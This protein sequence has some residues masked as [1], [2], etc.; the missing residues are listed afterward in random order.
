MLDHHKALGLLV[1]R[2]L[3][4]PIFLISGTEKIVN[5]TKTAESMAE[6]GLILVPFFLTAAIALELLG[7]LCILLGFRA[8]TGAIA[9]ALFLIPV[10]LVY[11]PFWAAQ[12]PAREPQLQH[13]L[14]NVT[15]MGGL[16]TLAAAGGGRY[17]LPAAIRKASLRDQLGPVLALH[18]RN[19]IGTPQEHAYLAPNGPT[20]PTAGPASGRD[21]PT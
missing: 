5:W 6:K 4:S 21:R 18:S 7:G 9:L 2:L 1:G 13:F 16:C 14:K 17:S 8:R 11:H 15:I 19:R 20:S 10:T 12:G 3:L